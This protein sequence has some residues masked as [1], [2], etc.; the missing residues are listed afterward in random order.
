LL[1]N[2][3]GPVPALII[4]GESDLDERNLGVTVLQKPVAPD[5]L[6]EELQRAMP[7]RPPTAAGG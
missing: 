4:S 5:K 7:H 2:E 3:Y 6:L 1:R